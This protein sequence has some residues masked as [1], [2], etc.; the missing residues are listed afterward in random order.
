MF[1]ATSLL[2]VYC[3]LHRPS[4]SAGCH[5]HDSHDGL[6]RHCHRR[7]QHRHSHQQDSLLVVPNEDRLR[8]ATQARFPSPL[9]NCLVCRCIGE[10]AIDRRWQPYR[11]CGF[12][13]LFRGTCCLSVSASSKLFSL[14]SV[15]SPLLSSALLSSRLS[16]SLSLSLCLGSPR[17][18]CSHGWWRAKRRASL[19]LDGYWFDVLAEWNIL[20]ILK[21]MLHVQHRIWLLGVFVLLSGKHMQPTSFVLLALDLAR[22]V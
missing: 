20:C 2:S 17:G 6:C 1:V 13:H 18:F 4:V 11:P 14:F 15:L 9:S 16:L 8:K 5:Y 7:R 10:T 21:L 12:R 19:V 22:S 3:P